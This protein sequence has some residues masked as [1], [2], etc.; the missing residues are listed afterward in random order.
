[1]DSNAIAERLR[2]QAETWRGYLPDDTL[3]DMSDHQFTESVLMAFGLDD[4]EM[5][6]YEAFEKLVDMF[7]RP[8]C[9]DVSDFDRESFKCSRCGYRVLSIDGAPDAA[10][11][12][13][14]EGGVVDFGCCP[15]CCAE[16]VE[17]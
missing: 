13:A 9:K 3:Y 7:D 16:V 2:G 10:K 14:P 6:V 1:M 11:L 15:S 4:L 17:R 5:P 8:T 12:V